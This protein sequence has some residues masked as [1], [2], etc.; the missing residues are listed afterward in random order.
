MAGRD[1]EAQDGEAEDEGTMTGMKPDMRRL[2]DITIEFDAH[3]KALPFGDDP[4]FDAKMT[5]LEEL[6]REMSRAL[7]LSEEEIARIEQESEVA[8]NKQIANEIEAALRVLPRHA[9]KKLRRMLRRRS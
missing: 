9:V 3:L 8:V 5:H 1:F 4:T 7:G 2:E 6:D